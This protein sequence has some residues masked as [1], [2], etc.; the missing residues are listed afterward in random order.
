M[1]ETIPVEERVKL[2]VE[3]HGQVQKIAGQLDILVPAIKA[4]QETADAANSTATQALEKSRNNQK[5]LLAGIPIIGVIASFA[6]AMG[7]TFF[8][9]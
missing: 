6:A 4:A 7:K 8:D 9:L 3:T 2:I 5:T 1:G